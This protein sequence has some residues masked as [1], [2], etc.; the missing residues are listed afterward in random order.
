M[1]VFAHHICEFQSRFVKELWG[2]VIGVWRDEAR[3][4]SSTWASR[5]WHVIHAFS[6]QAESRLLESPKVL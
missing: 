3:I 4:D 5:L 6:P 2:K 1:W